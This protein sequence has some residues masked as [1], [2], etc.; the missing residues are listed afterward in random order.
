MDINVLI[1]RKKSRYTLGDCV[2]DYAVFGDEDFLVSSQDQLP[3]LLVELGVYKS[4]SI[5]RRA[6]R[7]GEVPTGYTELKASKKNDIYIWNPDEYPQWY[8]YWKNL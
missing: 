7:I 4:C 1:V 3:N 5:A 8:S 6:G 2:G